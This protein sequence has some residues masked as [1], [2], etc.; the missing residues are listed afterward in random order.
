ME[1]ESEDPAT[2]ADPSAGGPD[3]PGADPAGA[4]VAKLARYGGPAFRK[5]YLA[6]LL[7]AS[8]RF[9]AAGNSRGAEYCLAKVAAAL[10]EATGSENASSARPG[11]IGGREL[12]DSPAERLGRQ[13]RL[14]RLGAAEKIL[15]RHGGMLS[16]LEYRTFGD[17]LEKLRAADASGPAAAKSDSLLLDL[18]RRLYARVLKSRKVAL[19]RRRMPVALA[20][21]APNSP[22]AIGSGLPVPYA[23]AQGSPAKPPIGPYNDRLNMEDVLALVADAD[24]TWVEEF[25]DL[26]R[27]LAGLKGILSS[28]AP[29]RR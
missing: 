19:R 26:Y 17:R 16:A 6:S 28:P 29:N 21:L 7:E 13:W 2:T 25:L 3:G 4:L 1:H 22:N 8:V 23:P 9:R 20:R 18:R 24:A 11:G 12:P 27:G 14:E 15:S 5:A 10:E